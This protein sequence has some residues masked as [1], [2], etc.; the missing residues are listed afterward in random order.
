MV[1]VVLDSIMKRHPLS[2]Y[3]LKGG[4]RL[5]P[6]PPQTVLPQHTPVNK[7]ESDVDIKKTDKNINLKSKV[8]KRRFSE[9]ESCESSDEEIVQAPRKN[10]FKKRS[11][12]TSDPFYDEYFYVDPPQNK[13]NNLQHQMQQL[14]QLQQQLQ[15][16]NTQQQ[17]KSTKSQRQLKLKQFNSDDDGE[18]TNDDDEIDSRV[19]HLTK[20]GKK[21]N[22][23][24]SL[25]VAKLRGNDWK[26]IKWLCQQISDNRV[27]RTPVIRSNLDA[28][29]KL[30]SNDLS[31]DEKLEVLLEGGP[32]F[33]KSLGHFMTLIE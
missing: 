21:L 29:K 4:Y 25:T 8:K 19:S 33:A 5:P 17:P 9:N 15:Q 12:P 16:S 27:E 31:A 2:K 6:P 13:N 7:E 24:T 26:S 10:K 22:K 18:N 20:L 1:S 3:C 28:I 30:A 11:E 23:D 14:L 32:G